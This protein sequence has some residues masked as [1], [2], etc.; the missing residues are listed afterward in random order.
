MPTTEDGALTG[1][2]TTHH[3]SSAADSYPNQPASSGSPETSFDLHLSA[4]AGNTLGGN[5]APYTLWI[6]VIDLTA[7]GTAPPASLSPGKITTQNFDGTG[8]NWAA[9]GSEYVSNQTFTIT[10]P[11]GQS[12]H[13][14]LY[15]ASLVSHNNLQV[16][17]IVGEPF[18]LC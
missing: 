17:R 3:G 18:T 15:T 1:L 8:P 16:W 12:G 7:P 4:V 10:I 6:Q 11:A 14:F 5:G 9:S 13:N 2:Y